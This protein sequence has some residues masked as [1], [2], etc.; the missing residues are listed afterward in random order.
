MHI[1]HSEPPADCS[2]LVHL[3]RWRGKHQSGRRAFTFLR[4]GEDEEVH[5]TY[6]ALD[7]GAQA[8]AAL[9]QRETREGD[10]AL[11]LYPSGLEYITAFL[12]C[13]YAAVIAV[14]A[15]PPS[16][17]LERTLGRL[18]TIVRDAEPT[19]VLTTTRLLPIGSQLAARDPAFAGIQWVA[20]DTA[21]DADAETWREPAID[22]EALAFLQYTSGSTTVP[23]GVMVSHGNLMHN[24]A[25]I[26][27]VVAL[28]EDS[29]AVSWLPL[30]HDMGLIGAVLQPIYAGFHC[31][32]MSPA[33][34]LQ[35][36]IRWLRAITRY[37][38]TVSPG[39]NFAYELCSRQI[40]PDELA[41]LDLSSWRV[42]LNGAEPVWPETLDRFTAAFG[43]CGL[44]REVFSPCYGLAEATLLVSGGPV[45]APP[46]VVHADKSALQRGQVTVLPGPETRHSLALVGS[47]QVAPGQRVLLVDPE[48]RLCRQPGQVGE[49]WVAG[50]SVARGYWHSPEVTEETFRAR[51][52]DG[53]QGTFL[54]T[55]DL[56]FVHDGQLFVTSRLKDLIIIRGSN[57]APQDIEH[58][59]EASHPALRPGCGIAFTVEEGV[60]PQL[61]IVHEVRREHSSVDCE[62]VASAIRKAVIEEHELEVHAVVL[63]RIGSV[64]KTSSGKLQRQACRHQYLDGTLRQTGESVRPGR[65]SR[66]S[67]D[68]RAADVVLAALIGAD[69]AQRLPLLVT[70]LR[71]RSAA[72]AGIPAEAVHADQPFTALGLDSLRLL[73]LKQRIETELGVAVP[74]ENFMDYPTA[75]AFAAPV[76]D[77]LEHNVGA[78]WAQVAGLT[79]EEIDARLAEFTAKEA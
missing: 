68:E 62:E 59:A 56:G 55:G 61:V 49:I 23:R 5:I 48:T 75:A 8:V 15:Y 41:G 50:A 6:G 70:Y 47:G 19:V 21:R 38:A 42:A 16:P 3:L 14:P 2:T 13:L 64:P 32:L 74:L 26:Q 17:R 31:V 12:G 9:L 4:D 11:L 53:G 24:Q 71:Q 22:G 35:N 39:P 40:K 1:E 37:Q 78:A 7:R 10:R 43:Q 65:M 29:V 34:F 73:Q 77:A 45:A 46:V 69:Q 20:T 51:L 72:A 25:L 57:H 79:D 67:G 33:H 18:R 52:A 36:P 30:Y 58:T 76:L 28:N 60:D 66:P 54:R 27:R 44:R 63:V